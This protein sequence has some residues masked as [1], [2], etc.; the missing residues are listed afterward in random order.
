MTDVHQAEPAEIGVITLYASQVK[1]IC[2]LLQDAGLA[3]VMV[4]PV[5]QFQG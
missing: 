1:R 2:I 4:G 3:D 5:E